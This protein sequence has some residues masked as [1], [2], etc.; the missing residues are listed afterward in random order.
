MSEWLKSAILTTPMEQL[1]VMSITDAATGSDSPESAWR[2]F[3]GVLARHGMR[4]ASLISGMPLDAPNPFARKAPS[5]ALGRLWDGDFD[6]RL[7]DYPG[8]VRRAADP[9]FIGLRPMLQYLSLSAAPLLIENRRLGASHRRTA[10]G[11]VSRHMIERFGMYH[12][13]VLPLTDPRTGKASFLA[14]WSDEDNDEFADFSRAN[15]SALHLA[16]HY[17]LSVVDRRWPIS[18]RL[19]SD[20]PLSDRE[21]SV[22]SLHATGLQTSE[23]AERLRISERSVREYVLRARNKLAAPSRAAAIARAVAAGRI[24]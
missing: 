12:T 9:D 15:L 5:R 2:R 8:D 23:V 22:L 19:E 17:F 18:R 14:A 13:L 1:D 3:S 24:G 4:R 20:R 7:R 10:V 16:G 6:G 21:R 11:A